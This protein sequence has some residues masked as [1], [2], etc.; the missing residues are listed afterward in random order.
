[1]RRRSPGP[2]VARSAGA[3]CGDG[4]RGLVRSRLDGHELGGGTDAA[5]ACDLVYEVEAL[6]GRAVLVVAPAGLG[7][8]PHDL[9]L[10]AVWVLGVEA[11]GGA[12]AGL[13]GEGAEVGQG[14]P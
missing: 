14:A 6:D 12:V 10:V 2:P 4:G 5:P 7:Q 9:E 11:L 1:M 3:A 13:T 8:H